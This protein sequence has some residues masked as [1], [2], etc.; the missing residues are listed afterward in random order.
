MGILPKSARIE[1]GE[2]LF[3]D[4]KSPQ[5]VDIAG[6]DPDGTAMR[7]IRGGRI[8]IIF[9]EPMTSLSPV[10]AVGNQIAEALHLHRR[11]SKAEGEEICIEMLRLVGFPEPAKAMRTYP[12]ELSGGLRQRAMIAMAWSAGRRC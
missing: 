10:H 3:K 12:F 6:L 5:P 4:P 2:I 9:Q 7:A 8:S 1:A 11:V